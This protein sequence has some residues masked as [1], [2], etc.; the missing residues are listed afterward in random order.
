MRSKKQVDKKSLSLPLDLV[1]EILLKLRSRSVPKLICVSKQ[2][3]SIIKGKYFTDLYLTRSS[4][5]PLLLLVFYRHDTLLFHSYSQ[6]NPSS[7]HSIS[8]NSFSTNSTSSNTVPRYQ[9]SPPVHGLICCRVRDSK[10]I[11]GNPNTGQ[12][13]TLPGD[14]T[15]TTYDR[16]FFGYDPLNDLY[17]VFSMCF[18]V[19]KNGYT[20]NKDHRVFTL[21]DDKAW[22]V[23][24]CK[25]P[26]YPRSQGLCKNGFL[27]Y[28]AVC[29]GLDPRKVVMCIDMRSEEFSLIT[30]PE[31]ILQMWCNY[32]LV[33]YNGKIALV[34]ILSWTCKFELW[35][36]TDVNKHQW[37]TCYFM[38]P[39]WAVLVGNNE[40]RC[41]GTIS[42]DEIIFELYTLSESTY[43]FWSL[44][45]LWNVMLMDYANATFI[46]GNS[47]RPSQRST[48]Y[49]STQAMSRRRL[50]GG[51][52]TVFGAA[53][54]ANS[55]DGRWQ[56]QRR[57]VFTCVSS[58]ARTTLSPADLPTSAFDSSSR[59]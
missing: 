31:D 17:K 22:R 38:V 15:W 28:I 53:A 25:Y 9:I 48:P 20:I 59:F 58:G 3:S 12:C 4:S 11:I 16:I 33:S 7:D 35:V 21:G 29:G 30:L 14:V 19:D 39:S 46:D 34:L 45:Y 44:F 27:Y 49:R 51:V 23:I 5:R 13:L 54:P 50:P 47:Q 1:I 55:G 41:M 2:W 52:R 32:D 8:L 6:D 36:L 56:L 37:T 57:V 24:E 10:I 43:P 42:T 18:G 26:Y 40:I